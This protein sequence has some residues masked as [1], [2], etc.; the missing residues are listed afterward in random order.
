MFNSEQGVVSSNDKD[1]EKSL[2]KLI[3]RASHTFLARSGR[4]V[5]YGVCSTASSDIDLVLQRAL[6]WLVC[7]LRALNPDEVPAV[8]QSW[9]CSGSIQQAP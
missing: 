1:Q 5:C 6:L 3:V 9:I 2:D 4:Y 8:H 7:W